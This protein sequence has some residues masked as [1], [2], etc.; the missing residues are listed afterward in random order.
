MGRRR[1]QH[2]GEAMTRDQVLHFNMG[3]QAAVKALD[4]VCAYTHSEARVIN[5]ATAAIKA[6]RVPLNKART[7][8]AKRGR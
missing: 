8:G 2:G 4:K 5:D 1:F 7:G 3:L 6:K